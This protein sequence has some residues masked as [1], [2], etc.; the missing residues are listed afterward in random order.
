M[1]LNLL[2]LKVDDA[3]V[4]D[5]AGIVFHYEDRVFRAISSDYVDLYTTLLSSGELSELFSCGLVKTW[6]AKDIAI[7]GFDLVLEHEKIQFISTWREWTS[8]MAKDAALLYLNLSILLE[9]K[10]L[11]LKDTEPENIQFVNGRPMWIDFGSIVLNSNKPEFHF[12]GFQVNHLIPL[13]LISKGFNDLGFSI[14]LEASIERLKKM[15]LKKPL[16]YLPLKAY[17]SYRKEKSTHKKLINLENYVASLDMQISKGYWT[18]YPEHGNP[19]PKFEN[20]FSKKALCVFEA[21]KKT[22]GATLLDMA[23]NKGWFSLLAANMGFSVV[24]FDLDEVSIERL[25]QI[26]KKESFPVLPLKLDFLVPS[27]PYGYNLGKK[28]SFERLSS[29]VVLALAIIHHLVFKAFVRFDTFSSILSKYTKKYA[30]VE[31]IPKEDQYVSQWNVERFPWYNLDNFID[32]LSIYFNEIEV[33]DSDP[34][35]RKL[36]ICKKS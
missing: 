1:M 16:C 30:L 7:Q 31:F 14:Y 27:H 13:W 32:S 12:Q 28:S 25:Y 36:L 29:D 22:K 10:G 24:C 17:W 23:G 4:V 11:K 5:Q 21:L 20:T 34:H 18:D 6:I 15:F 2:E 3:S 8:G 26:V 9:K 35:P 19:D 33:V